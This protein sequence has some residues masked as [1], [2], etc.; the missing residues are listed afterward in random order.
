LSVLALSLSVTALAALAVAPATAAPR[1]GAGPHRV[2]SKGNVA[3]RDDLM[4]LAVSEETYLTDVNHYGSFKQLAHDGEPAEVDRG[5]Q[6]RIVHIDGNRGYCLRGEQGDDGYR[7][8]YDSMD[9]GVLSKPCPVTTTGRSGGMRHGAPTRQLAGGIR[10][11][12]LGEKKYLAAHPSGYGSAR[13]LLRHGDA[14]TLAAHSRLEVRWYDGSA[15]YCLRGTERTS[16]DW[17]DSRTG[18]H[19]YGCGHRPKGAKSGGGY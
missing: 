3:V 16:V 1:V 17:Y 8:W 2:A 15:A 7:A 19:R 18:T 5:V 9:G 10:A 12:R 11:L 6:L 4:N 13:Q 14:P